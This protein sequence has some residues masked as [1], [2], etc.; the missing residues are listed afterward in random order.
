LEALAERVQL[1]SVDPPVWWLLLVRVAPS[2]AGA[3]DVEAPTLGTPTD[4]PAS[5]ELGHDEA[6]TVYE[7][8]DCFSEIETMN[9]K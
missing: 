5:P 6:A 3:G 2:L 1:A 7:L 9:E 4:A 8:S